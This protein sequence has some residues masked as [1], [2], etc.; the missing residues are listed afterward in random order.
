MGFVVGGTW[1]L[2]NIVFMALIPVAERFGIHLVLAL[3][4]FGYLFSG[5]LGLS[6]ILKTRT[7]LS[8]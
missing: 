2:A 4:P 3:T 1:A 7:R 8:E 6:I 5:V